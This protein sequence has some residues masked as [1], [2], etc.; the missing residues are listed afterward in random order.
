MTEHRILPSILW[1]LLGFAFAFGSAALTADGANEFMLIVGV[2]G[3]FTL[4]GALAMYITQRPFGA[5]NRLTSEQGKDHTGA[6]VPVFK[7]YRAIIAASASAPCV[8]GVGFALATGDALL[9]V[10]GV[11][12]ALIA[13]VGTLLGWQLD[14]EKLEA[15]GYR[16]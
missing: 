16:W 2:V 8:I 5:G 13:I 4:A 3:A 11:G 15:E 12:L 14:R 6:N 10:L 7:R 9:A 1:T